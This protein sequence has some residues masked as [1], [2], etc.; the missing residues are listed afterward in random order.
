MEFN[1]PVKSTPISGYGR[2][3]APLP[4]SEEEPEA[5]VIDE[6]I[7]GKLSLKTVKNHYFDFDT[8]KLYHKKIPCNTPGYHSDHISCCNG[9]DYWEY[10]HFIVPSLFQ[11]YNI[12]PADRDNFYKLSKNIEANYPQ[13]EKLDPDELHPGFQENKTSDTDEYYSYVMTIEDIEKLMP[14]QETNLD[15]H[16]IKAENIK[17]RLINL[18]YSNEMF[19]A[20]R[21]SMMAQEQKDDIPQKLQEV[22]NK[23]TEIEKL[24]KDNDTKL[25]QIAKL[26][27]QNTDHLEP[28]KLGKTVK[29][30]VEEAN[31]YLPNFNGND[32]GNSVSFSEFHRKLT[33]YS[34]VNDLSEIA[35][36][37]L[38]SCKL[39]GAP[40][41]EYFEHREKSLKDILQVLHDRFGTAITMADRIRMLETI[42]R[43]K[44][45]SIASCMNRVEVLIDKTKNQ[46]QKDDQETRRRILLTENLR[47]LCSKNARNAI[48]QKQ[49]NAGENGFLLNY[50]DMLKIAKETEMLEDSPWETSIKY[51][52]MATH[53]EKPMSNLPR[54]GSLIS[55]NKNPYE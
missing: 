22:N 33:T 46:A 9:Q 55:E 34:E 37:S 53:Y 47:K 43:D 14:S 15:I 3:G 27:Q 25:E 45:E 18:H 36:K 50:K 17:A 8:A 26:K 51:E 35:I 6:D 1:K 39:Q 20:L 48:M 42:K 12:S 52:T 29:I 40:H 4:P 54:I 31:A 13:F 28:I 7:L 5:Q 10:L 30:N 24:I 11:Y 38:L 16:S 2:Y 19:Q 21:T 49:S 23:I 32:K 41:S 44:E